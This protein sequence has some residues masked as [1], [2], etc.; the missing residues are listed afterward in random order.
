MTWDGHVERVADDVPAIPIA[1]I[2]DTRVATAESRAALPA[3]VPRD[4]AVYTVARATLL[5]AALASRDASL[6]AA[7]A[8]DRLHETY[9]GAAAPHLAE[10]RADLPD[11]ALGATLSGS[12]PTVIV[13]SERD[14]SDELR[15]RYPQ[16]EVSVLPVTPRGAALV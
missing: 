1:V 15:T 8:D 13:W 3:S 16:H 6:F 14:I 5:G 9:R 11:G 2:P 7:S 12:G 10:L 4:D